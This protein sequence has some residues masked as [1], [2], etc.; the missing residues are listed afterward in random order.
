M[1]GSMYWLPRTPCAGRFIDPF[2]DPEG[3]KA[4]MKMFEENVPGST[5]VAD[6]VHGLEKSCLLKIVGKFRVQFHS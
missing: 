3:I 5:P 2:H 6:L 4:M 1:D